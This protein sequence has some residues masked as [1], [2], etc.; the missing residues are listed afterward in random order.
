[1]EKNENNDEKSGPLLL[2]QVD[3]LIASDCKGD[4]LCKNYEDDLEKKLQENHIFIG[5][6]NGSG[7]G[8]D[9]VAA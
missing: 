4:H 5:P 9:E 3:P 8:Y 6:Y 1:M 7:V 2:M